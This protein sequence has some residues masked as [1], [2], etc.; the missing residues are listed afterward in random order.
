MAS[1][2]IGALAMIDDP[3]PTLIGAQI[4]EQ[5][6]DPRGRIAGVFVIAIDPAAFGDAASYRAMAAEH[7]AA[8]K[9]VPAA[10]GVAEVLTPGEIEH[11]TRL[12][13]GRD[14]IPLPEATWRDLEQ[15]AGRFKLTMPE[16]RN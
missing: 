15:L 1:A 11:R 7:M 14:G 9:R 6:P 12:E 10:D 5:S 13:R 2:L 3:D 4:R 8:A 16:P